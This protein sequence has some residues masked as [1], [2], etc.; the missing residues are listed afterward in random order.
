MTEANP[1]EL[2]RMSVG[3]H[4]E[5][6]RRRVFKCVLY[7]GGALVF[8]LIFND[9]IQKFVLAKPTA[10]LVDLYGADKAKMLVTGT[11]E[12]FLTWLKIAM[13]AAFLIASPLIVR[14]LW[15][16]VAAGL[17]PKEKKYVRLFAPISYVLF[18]GGVAFL[19]FAVLPSALGFLY[20]F[21]I[22]RDFLE[23]KPRYSDYVSFYITM[24]LI[25]G[26]V[27]Q[28]PLIMLFF[29]STGL[30]KPATF[31]KYRRH[32]IVGAVAVLA[33]VSPTGDAVTL[34]LISA[35][36]I[37][38]YEGGLLLGRFVTREKKE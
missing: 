22:D 25:M 30:V 20:D 31:S 33:V 10:V 6:L 27:F 9:H 19:Y 14:E 4:L 1:K 16:F 34:L 28:L 15:G 38:L 3:E 17:Y 37:I 32:F 8:C 21:G 23:M 36:V 11:V 5:E 7:L 18:L 13:V 29:I 2:R 35:P 26:I 24:S 12:G